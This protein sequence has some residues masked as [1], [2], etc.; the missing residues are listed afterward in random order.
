M[1]SVRLTW[2]FKIRTFL[3][4]FLKYRFLTPF[5]KFLFIVLKQEEN[6]LYLERMIKRGEVAVDVG[7]NVGL[8]TIVLA[9]LVG[10]DGMV[11]A[12]EPFE[13]SFQRL[14]K[15]VK[16]PIRKFKNVNLYN[17]AL[18]SKDLKVN[19]N[20]PRDSRGKVKDSYIYIDNQTN[21]DIDLR[22]LDTILKGSEVKI[23]FI[24]IDVEGSELGV[25]EGSIATLNK[26]HPTV[27]CELS[28]KWSARY[29]SHPRE[30]KKF[31]DKLG[32]ETFSLSGNKLVK[33]QK[34][35]DFRGGDVF[36]VWKENVEES[37]TKSTEGTVMLL[38]L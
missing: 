16:G 6:L 15:N 12:F 37:A 9:R 3:T 28:E 18:G 25:L 26:Y 36:F 11:L 21:G 35:I 27:L 23:S 10:P 32:Y 7:A 5:V 8:F 33:F 30:V 34:E 19:L 31:M 1:L 22:R 17:L 29:N 13:A 20:L 14:R 24:K 2:T 4:I 38:L